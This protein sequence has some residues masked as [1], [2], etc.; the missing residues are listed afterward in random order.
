MV[1][2][3]G[4]LKVEWIQKVLS[5]RD[6]I[7]GLLVNLGEELEDLHMEG[8]VFDVLGQLDHS[9]HELDDWVDQ[10]DQLSLVLADGQDPKLDAVVELPTVDGFDCVLGHVIPDVSQ[11][12]AQLSDEDEP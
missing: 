5:D 10:Q 7:V 2:I 1:Q 9:N 12:Q 3:I 4:S 6:E 8:E 11:M